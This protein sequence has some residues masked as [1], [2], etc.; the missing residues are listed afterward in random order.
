MRPSVKSKEALGVVKAGDGDVVGLI[1]VIEIALEVGLRGRVE[2]A[3]ADGVAVSNEIKVAADGEMFDADKF[4]NVVEVI[5]HILEA[6]GLLVAHHEADEI[7]T[8][9]AAGFGHAADGIVGLRASEVGDESAAGGVGEEDGFGGG[10]KRV[11]SGL[12]GTMG[13]INRHADLFHALH[14]GCAED[15][16][17]AIAAF[18]E[19][20]AD[21]VIE[22]IG[23]LREALAKAEEFVNV[24]GRAKVSGILEREQD[25]GTAGLVGTGNVGGIVDAN[26]QIGMGGEE[27]IPGSE[28]AEAGF[29]VSGAG[30]EREDVNAGVDKRFGVEFGECLWIVEPALNFGRLFGEVFK[31]ELIEEI[32]H[33][34]LFDEPHGARGVFGGGLGEEA[35]A[36]VQDGSREPGEHGAPRGVEHW[37]SVALGAQVLV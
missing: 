35:E 22:V 34:R 31:E 4:A 28:K 26:E 15:R 33:W 23:E 14:D 12:I 17:A 30:A 24:G 16:E 10:G 32:D 11:E 3:T 37:R 25:A 36:I 8:H 6:D 13:H 1:D 29:V 20:A 5:E 2:A 18:E 7:D 9:D 19:A 27:T 21:A